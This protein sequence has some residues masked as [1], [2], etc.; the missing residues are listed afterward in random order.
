MDI[1]LMTNREGDVIGATGGGAAVGWTYAQYTAIYAWI[2][3]WVGQ[4][5]VTLFISCVTLIVTH[6]FKRELDRRWPLR[7]RRGG[8]SATAAETS[9]E[10]Q[11]ES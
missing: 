3:A 8:D 1:R 6:F 9:Q 5:A 10:N 7:R 2:P 4:L 11:N